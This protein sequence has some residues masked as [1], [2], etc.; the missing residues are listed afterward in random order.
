M[1][2]KAEIFATFKD[3]FDQVP[4][5]LCGEGG[6]G[7]FQVVVRITMVTEDAGDVVYELE[8]WWV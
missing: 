3:L 1:S 8:Q 5:Y 7:V 4:G 2:R 6:Q